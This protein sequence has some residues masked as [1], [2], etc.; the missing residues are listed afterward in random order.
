MTLTSLFN[1]VAFLWR[2]NTDKIEVLKERILRFILDDFESAYYHL[3]EKVNCAS[4]Y[5][6]RIHNMLVFFYKSS[7]LTN[8]PIYM[9]NMFTFRCTMY[10]L[11][12]NYILTLPIPKTTTY[13]LR[14]FSY[15]AA[16]QWNSL[17]DFFRTANFNDFKK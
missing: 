2:A 14:S 15:H 9:K 8:Y 1:G 3:L 10:N 11:R 12:G 16:N 17:S 4:L 7:F 6:K 13:G 5:N